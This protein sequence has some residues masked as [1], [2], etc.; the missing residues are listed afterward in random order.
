M[1]A[2]P[3]ARPARFVLAGRSFSAPIS[4]GLPAQ[5][6]TRFCR[7]PGAIELIM[8]RSRGNAYSVMSL[9]KKNVEVPPRPVGGGAQNRKR[10][11]VAP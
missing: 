10:K 4:F 3:I 1:G 7:L 8:G 9:L 6:P 11:P 2:V 5:S